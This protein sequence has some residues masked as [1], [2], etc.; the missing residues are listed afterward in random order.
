MLVRLVQNQ[1]ACVPIVVTVFG[2]LMPVIVTR[3]RNEEFPMLVTGNPLMM[4]GMTTSPA[5]PVYP[6]MVIAPLLFV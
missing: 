3:A 1:N 6:V 4:L 2:M 5:G